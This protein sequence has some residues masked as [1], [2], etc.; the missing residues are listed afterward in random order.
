[1]SPTEIVSLQQISLQQDFG[2]DEVWR[3]NYK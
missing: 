3:I 1:M 2:D